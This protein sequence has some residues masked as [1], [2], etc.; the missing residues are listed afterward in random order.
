MVNGKKLSFWLWCFRRFLSP[1]YKEIKPVNLK[2]NQLLT[3]TVSAEASNE[4]ER[5]DASPAKVPT[6]SRWDCW[7]EWMLP[8]QKC[9]TVAAPSKEFVAPPLEEAQKGWRLCVP[10]L[11]QYMCYILP[12]SIGGQG[13]GILVAGGQ[14]WLRDPLE[15]SLTK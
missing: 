7:K 2:G 4:V 5:M 13:R 9:L 1:L 8:L 14:E 10:C 11:P 15:P 6:R 3:S 12:S